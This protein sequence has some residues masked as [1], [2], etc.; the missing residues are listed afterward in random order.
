MD[1]V[2]EALESVDD[3]HLVTISRINLDRAL[4]IVMAAGSWGS[5]EASESRSRLAES[6]AGLGNL[7][8]SSPDVPALRNFI[9]VS[10]EVMDEYG[11]AP[12]DNGYWSFSACRLANMCAVAM[13]AQTDFLGY[14]TDQVEDLFEFTERVDE[15]AAEELNVEVGQHASFASRELSYWLN[16]AEALADSQGADFSALFDSGRVIA[17]QY[18]EIIQH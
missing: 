3:A 1:Q 16:L 18:L 8:Q 9:Q 10:T 7:A 15:Y 11:E 13:E 12:L 17:D 14:V 4:R 6:A 5:W 2:I